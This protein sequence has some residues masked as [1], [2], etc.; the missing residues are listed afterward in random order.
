MKGMKAR[1]N[2]MCSF[3]VHDDAED[4]SNEYKLRLFSDRTNVLLIF[5]DDS[6]E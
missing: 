1:Y 3:F 6:Y 5:P 2:H 4:V